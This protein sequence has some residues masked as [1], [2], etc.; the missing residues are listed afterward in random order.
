MV[1]VVMILV[2]Q[3]CTE[4]SIVKHDEFGDFFPSIEQLT[5][6]VA[7][8]Y[9]LHIDQ[10]NN[11]VERKTD[12]RYRVYFLMDDTVTIDHYNAGFDKIQMQKMRVSDGKWILISDVSL[13]YRALNNV[14]YDSES[15]KIDSVTNCILDWSGEPSILR[16]Y[17]TTED[18]QRII[19]NRISTH[20]DT[21]I[22]E[23][24][25]RMMKG[26]ET[27]DIVQDQDTTQYRYEISQTYRYSHGLVSAV[28]STDEVR[29]ELELVEI[30]SADAFLEL[31][32]HG[33]YRV[34]HIDTSLTIDDAETFA[35]CYHATKINDYYNDRRA[36]YIGKTGRL[37][38]D[39]AD[40]I[41][42]TLFDGQHGYLTFRFVINCEGRAGWF[43]ADGSTF[44]YRDH[45]F[46]PALVRA[47]YKVLNQPNRWQFLTVNGEARDAYTYIILKIEDGVLTEIIP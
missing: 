20:I 19:T 13:N 1:L 42:P 40:E 43:V 47:I 45:V 35:P 46:S 15:I 41:D 39:L 2:W 14:E 3:A 7:Y 29:L 22:A 31:A 8:K 33:G 16:Q 18:Y 25:H 27:Y 26:Y 32:D 34:G 6:G 30:M 44:D 28:R 12:I 9:Y 5:D 37:R 10:P 23:M 17:Y 11:D 38:K 21:A 36:Q 4:S 24:P